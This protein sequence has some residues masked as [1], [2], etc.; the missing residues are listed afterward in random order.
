MASPNVI[1]VGFKWILSRLIPVAPST[2]E[3]QI[4]KLWILKRIPLIQCADLS[5]DTSFRCLRMRMTGIFL[6]WETWSQYSIGATSQ[7]QHRP[8]TPPLPLPAA[9]VAG[10]LY[11][12]SKR[13][14]GKETWPGF[15]TSRG[16]SPAQGGASPD[17]KTSATPAT[18]TAY[19]RYWFFHMQRCCTD[20]G[21]ILLWWAK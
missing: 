19:C 20:Y 14:S 7:S 3:L 4:H 5:R 15:G 6:P 17:S 18:W 8:P 1:L 10:N 9:A 11:L 12:A 21:R 13:R 2:R 16:S